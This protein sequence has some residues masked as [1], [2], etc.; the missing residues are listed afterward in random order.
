MTRIHDI[1]DNIRKI[2]G[3]KSDLFMTA[4]VIR[5]D[6]D[7]CTVKCSDDTY[8]DVLLTPLVSDDETKLL[9]VPSPGSTVLIA[10][11]SSGERRL[12]QIIVF[13]QIESITI[14]G[15][16][17]GGLVNISALTDKLNNLV[18]VVN[19]HTHT[20]A[21]TGTASA[22]TGTASA[23]ITKASQFRASDYEDTK[24]QH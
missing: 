23:I 13:S 3:A 12:L 9:I 10:D 19:A 8:E 4:Q 14:N 24:I 15:G 1:K 16:K 7:T 11:L 18:S 17:L 5:V 20:V 6:A 22:Q 21:T 2:A